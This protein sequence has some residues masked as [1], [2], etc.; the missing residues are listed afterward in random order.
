MDS[1][2][3]STEVYKRF[4]KFHIILAVILFLTIA[5]DPYLLV[6]GIPIF[7]FIFCFLNYKIALGQKKSPLFGLLIIPSLF[8][9]MFLLYMTLKNFLW[10]WFFSAKGIFSDLS[11]FIFNVIQIFTLLSMSVV[12]FYIF[13]SAIFPLSKKRLIKSIFVALIVFGISFSTIL[14]SYDKTFKNVPESVRELYPEIYHPG[15]TTR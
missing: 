8:L 13:I 15:T 9:T 7:A 12:Y 2:I 11:T 1:Q 5:M 6:Y 10:P 3:Y 4:L 14:Y